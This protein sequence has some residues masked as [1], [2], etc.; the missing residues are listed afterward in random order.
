[1]VYRIGVST[2]PDS[3]EKAV[4]FAALDGMHD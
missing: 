2:L 3:G 1:M 4:G